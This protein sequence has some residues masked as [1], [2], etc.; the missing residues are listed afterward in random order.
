MSDPRQAEVSS[1]V[2]RLVHFSCRVVIALLVGS[3][4]A[5]AQNAEP[6]PSKTIRYVVPYPPGAFNDTLGRIISQKLQDAWGVPVVVENR[7]GGGTLIGTEA[8]AKAAPD[9]YTLLGV[10]FPFGA[11]PSIYKNLPYDTLNDF[12]PLIFAGQTPNLLVVKPSLPVRSVK[13]LIDY[14]KANPGKVSYGSTGIGSSNHLSM[15]LFKKMA[16][17]DIVHVPYK[18]S[19]PMVND[20]LGGHIDVAFDNTP[21]VLPQ[22]N[23]AKL[24]AL[25]VSSTARS[26]L[27]SDIPTV[28][29]AGVPG[30]EVNVW[31]GVVGPAG[32]PAEIVRKLNTEINAILQQKDVRQRFAD[33]GVDPVGGTPSQFADHIRAEVQK[34]AKVVKD[35]GITPE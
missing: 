23:G 3:V 5:S 31:F 9:G 33:Q 18:G 7:P 25:G 13:E 11:N 20:M 17:I 24:R 10:A 15:E 19:A 1:R 8:V 21:N 6:Y 26:T 4:C 16:G 35:A 28:A 27:A 22:V 29:E 32:M 2:Q 14:A 30:Y 12:T 34:W